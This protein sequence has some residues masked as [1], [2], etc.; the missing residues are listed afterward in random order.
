L[1]GKDCPEDRSQDAW[2][3]PRRGI[4]LDAHATI[5]TKLTIGEGVGRLLQ[6]GRM[7]RLRQA[8]ALGS[9]SALS[10][11]FPVLKGLDDLTLLQR[12]D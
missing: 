5:S 4:K 10:A 8:W 2:H 9:F 3:C 7:A 1:N 12:T 11:A 6:T